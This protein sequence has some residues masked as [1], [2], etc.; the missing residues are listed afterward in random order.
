M[1]YVN[2]QLLTES[3]ENLESQFKFLQEKI[4]EIKANPNHVRIKQVRPIRRNE[5]NEIEPHKNYCIPL[6]AIRIGDYG[7]ETWTY[8]KVAPNKDNN[9]RLRFKEN[10][11]ILKYVEDLN[12][13]IDYEFIFFLVYLCPLVRDGVY[14]LEDKAKEARDKIQKT[15]EVDD[16]KFL[17]NSPHSH[18]SPEYN[19]GDESVLRLIA[20]AWGVNKASTKDIWIIRDELFNAVYAS[21][22]NYQNTGRGFKEFLSENKIDDNIKNRA[23]LQ[24]AYDENVISI[25]IEQ[26]KWIYTDSKVSICVV[27]DYISLRNGKGEFAEGEWVNYL[28]KYTNT[29]KPEIISD[30]RNVLEGI[31]KNVS[32]GT[33]NTNKEENIDDIMAL[34]RGG[35][36]KKAS[37]LDLYSKHDIKKMRNDEIKDVIIKELG[38][39]KEPV[40]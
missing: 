15:R 23:L 31:I 22:Q 27:P 6:T 19:N 1:F 12:P 7:T 32:T 24:R 16:I 25:D 39:A 28:F 18:I 30:I 10:H 33:V 37:K 29:T 17:I 26:R 9:G 13:K 36:M 34:D 38:F 40:Q 21:N 4:D 14:I 20:S 5:T 8:T 3:N 35:L 2:E 11:K